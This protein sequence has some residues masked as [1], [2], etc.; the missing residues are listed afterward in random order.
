[1]P[2]RKYQEQEGAVAV[3]EELKRGRREE[4]EEAR[5]K[6]QKHHL[7]KVVVPVSSRGR[8]VLE[9]FGKCSMVN[10]GTYHRVCGN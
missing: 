2:S 4:G 7:A 10:G 6:M 9:R 3:V 1:L 5:V 8:E